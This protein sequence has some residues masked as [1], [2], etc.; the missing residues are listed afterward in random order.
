MAKRTKYGSVRHS[1][2]AIRTAMHKE[3]V[4]G[5][6]TLKTVV[7][8]G[9]IV[10]VAPAN[11]PTATGYRATVCLGGAKLALQKKHWTTHNRA[12]CG[13]ATGRSPTA[14]YKKATIAMLKKVK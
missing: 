3:I 9:Q 7:A 14:A 10:R 13:T 8:T 12:R 11:M 2:A 5:R 1:P 6:Y 4:E